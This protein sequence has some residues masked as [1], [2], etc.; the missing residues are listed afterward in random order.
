[1]KRMIDI[2]L[3]AFGVLLTLPLMLMVAAAVRLGT[4]GPILYSQER[5]GRSRRPFRVHKF[6]TMRVHAEQE[7]GPVWSWDGDPR[8]TRLGRVL[9][10]SHLDELPQLWN[11]LRG[12]MSLVGPRPERAYFVEQFESTIAGYAE[13][14]AVQP[15]LTGLSQLRS[16]YDS[17]ARTVQRKTRY[18]RLYVRRAS[19]WL[20]A[21]IL[22]ETAYCTMILPAVSPRWMRPVASYGPVSRRDQL[23]SWSNS[24]P[25][26]SDAAA[27]LTRS[28]SRRFG[29]GTSGS[30]AAGQA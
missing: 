8:V 3:A 25:P 23:D 27:V 1:M 12:E 11:V 19:A 13:R 2:L 26:P 14:F 28:S 5:L 21:R 16:G 30:V 29:T 15:G 9:R 7:T 20:D 10:A 6:R 18:D 22:F 24:V 17:S 4:P